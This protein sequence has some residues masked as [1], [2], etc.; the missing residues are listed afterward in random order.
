MPENEISK[1]EIQIERIIDAIIKKYSVRM[2]VKFAPE[3]APSLGWIAFA[4]PLDKEKEDY[5]SISV[6][7][8]SIREA[9]VR[10]ARELKS[11]E[12]KRKEDAYRKANKDK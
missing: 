6:A 11:F 3:E 10:L 8:G 5:W 7:G 4:S 12:E 2:I 9:V 1:K